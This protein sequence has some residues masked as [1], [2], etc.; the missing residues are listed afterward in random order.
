VAFGFLG[1]PASFIARSVMTAI[2][3]ITRSVMNRAARTQDQIYSNDDFVS[4]KQSW[5]RVADGA[6]AAKKAGPAKMAGPVLDSFPPL[7]FFSGLS[8][9]FLAGGAG[10]GLG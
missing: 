1:Q 5:V 4:L 6:C 2:V 8:S 9:F 7:H 10:G 3:G